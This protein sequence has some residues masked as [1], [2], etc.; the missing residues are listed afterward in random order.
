MDRRHRQRSRVERVDAQVRR[1]AGVGSLAHE[2]YPLGQRAVVRSG[3]AELL[4]V[5][6]AGGVHHHRQMHVVKFSQPDELGLPAQEL[7]LPV[8]AQ[9]VPVLNLDVFLGRNRH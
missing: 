2:L 4:L 5:G 9:L 3:Q 7:D 8:P 1:P 6:S